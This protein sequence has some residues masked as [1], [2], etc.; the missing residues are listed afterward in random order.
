MFLVYI[1]KKMQTIYNTTFT[2]TVLGVEFIGIKYIYIVV[3]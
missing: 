1:I 2:I 3:Q